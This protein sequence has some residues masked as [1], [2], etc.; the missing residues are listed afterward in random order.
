MKTVNFRSQLAC[1]AVLI[2]CLCAGGCQQ[3]K[4]TPTAKETA[5][6]EWNGARAAVF[7]SLANDQYKSGNF[8]KSRQTV[9]EALKLTPNNA[10]L[11]VLSPNLAISGGQLELAKQH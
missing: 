1:H 4:T 11:H 9:S 6:R 7:A 10:A 2:A 8:E 3:N 5:T